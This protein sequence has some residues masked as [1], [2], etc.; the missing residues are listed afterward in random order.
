M[1]VCMDTHIYLCVCGICVCGIGSYGTAVLRVNGD[2]E[3]MSPVHCSGAVRE[4]ASGH[5]RLLV[6]ASSGR[7]W[8]V[9]PAA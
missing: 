2:G 6:C 3:S 9:C 1:S 4:C 7:I 5:T 8:T